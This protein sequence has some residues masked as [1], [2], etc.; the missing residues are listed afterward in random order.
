MDQATQAVDEA[1]EATG[2]PPPPYDEIL[3]GSRTPLG[4]P[5]DQS[6]V[7]RRAE[8]PLAW[9][10]QYW[11]E[12]GVVATLHSESVNKVINDMEKDLKQR[13]FLA[14]GGGFE[15]GDFLLKI[16]CF[17][18][19][20][21]LLTMIEHEQNKI[22]DHDLRN[23]VRKGWL[24]F[25]KQHRFDSICRWASVP[26]QSEEVQRYLRDL[27]RIPDYEWNELEMR[28]DALGMTTFAATLC[29]EWLKT[30][31]NEEDRTRSN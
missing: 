27:D 8:D 21:T 1:R 17:D 4:E 19:A 14:D 18:Y 7:I 11:H 6:E 25:E 28:T 20:R 29:K 13:Q 24:E 31:T 23:K 5:M 3:S 9:H 16:V 30:N 22:P 12:L 2:T 10:L 26:K 15:F